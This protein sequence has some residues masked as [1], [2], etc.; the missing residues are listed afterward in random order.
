M[1]PLSFTEADVRGHTTEKVFGRGGD[2]CKAGQVL[3]LIRRGDVLQAAVEGSEDEPYLV[4]VTFSSNGIQDAECDCPYGE[5]WD[6]WC[7]HIVAAL[8]LCLESPGEIEERPAL[9]TLLSG[10]DRAQLQ[11]LVQK[12]AKDNL[13]LLNEIEAQVTRLTRKQKP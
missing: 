2:Y 8:L 10:L 13:S 5:E 7:K 9:Q 12:L 3:S 4:S 6:G 1:K 11:T